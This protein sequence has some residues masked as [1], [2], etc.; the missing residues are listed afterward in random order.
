MVIQDKY[1]EICVKCNKKYIDTRYEWYNPCHHF[2]NGKID[3]FIQEM[4]KMNESNDINFKLIP[5]DQF[6]N[7]EEMRKGISATVYSAIWKDGPLYYLHD[8]KKWIRKPNKKFTL[9][10]LHGSQDEFL[11]EA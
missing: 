10:C 1:H 5:Y 4:R 6:D 9:K 2:K 3:N 7:I 11:N 8:E